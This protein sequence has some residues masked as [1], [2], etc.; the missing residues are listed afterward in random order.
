[1][2]DLPLNDVLIESIWPENE[3]ETLSAHLS[4]KIF[5][6]ISISKR[7]AHDRKHDSKT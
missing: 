4:K 5:V 2:Y 6:S 3:E 1:M 7:E